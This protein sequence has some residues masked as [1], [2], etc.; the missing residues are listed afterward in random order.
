MEGTATF[1]GR[2]AW[3]LF[4]R[5]ENSGIEEPFGTADATGNFTRQGPG[6]K[7]QNAAPGVS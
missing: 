3:W 5:F 1:F 2:I 6:R 7:A 4:F